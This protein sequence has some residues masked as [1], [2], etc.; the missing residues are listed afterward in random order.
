MLINYKVIYNN[1]FI[2]TKIKIKKLIKKKIQILY[3]DKSK[4][5]QKI[6]SK[7]HQ[8]RNLLK[9]SKSNR[10]QTVRISW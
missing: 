8:S 7:N 3:S 5:N 9:K 6:W 1:K 2:I 10:M 4:Q